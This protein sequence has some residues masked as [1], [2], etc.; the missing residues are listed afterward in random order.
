METLEEMCELV[1][2]SRC[3]PSPFVVVEIDK[4]NQTIFRQWS[5]QLTAHY[6]K[7]YLFL[8]RSVRELEFTKEHPRLVRYR[9][10]FN[11]TWET[12]VVTEKKQNRN[13]FLLP[14]PSHKG[15]LPENML[16]SSA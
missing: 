9:C 3:K 16:T 11:G 4:K 15:M 5:Q 12:S 2:T 13:E 10:S 1:Q 8:S 6:R 14:D 7:K